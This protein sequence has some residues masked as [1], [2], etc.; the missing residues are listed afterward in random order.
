MINNYINRSFDTSH[1][2]GICYG[3]AKKKKTAHEKSQWD[4]IGI[5]KYEISQQILAVC[6]LDQTV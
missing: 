1:D 2:R 4:R 5:H 6:T 3:R